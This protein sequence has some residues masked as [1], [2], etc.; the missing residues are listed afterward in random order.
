MTKPLALLLYE[1]LLPGTQLVNRL[2]D[3]GYR[4]QCLETP[5]SLV[6]EAQQLKPLVIFADFRARAEEV[7]Q[8]VRDLRSFSG[9]SHIPV[10]AYA[11]PGSPAQHTSA[12]K[13]GATLIAASDGI[14]EQLP[15]LLEQALDVE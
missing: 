7:A 1:K 6:A 3:L 12:T 13:T 8:A 5:G 4:V 11:D 15:L 2:R 9:T 10:I 14:I